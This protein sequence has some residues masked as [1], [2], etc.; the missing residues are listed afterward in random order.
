MGSEQREDDVFR[1]LSSPHRRAILDLLR[2]GPATTSQVAGRLEG[3]SRYAAMQHLQVLVETGL[4]VV[5]R[6][7][8]ERF[9]HLNA[10]PLRELYE[11]WVGRFA[12]S[13]AAGML[14]LQRHL[15][16]EDMDTPYR[17]IEIHNQIR[18]RAPRERVFAALTTE[19]AKWYPYNYGGERLKDIVFEPRV[20][21]QVYED[22]GDGTGKLYGTVTW[23]DPP[24]LISMTSHLG[25]S[26]NIE[27]SFGLEQDGDHTVLTQKMVAYGA[28]T[29]E[30]AE[31][32]RSHG[33]I[34][35][36]EAQLRA[37]VEA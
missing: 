11:R 5:S 34:K 16:G 30:G 4:V 24:K 12:D 9:N 31:G 23:Y 32:I 13:A 21:G 18:L 3:L 29:D 17:V 22:W 7:G 27:G 2:T 19:Q 25:G 8:R 28:I 33:D 6:E 35:A 36:T 1:A 15:E 10:V 37:Y 26:V 14:S 20:G